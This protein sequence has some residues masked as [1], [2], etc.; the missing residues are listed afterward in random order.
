MGFEFLCFVFMAA[1]RRQGHC[2]GNGINEWGPDGSFKEA[3]TL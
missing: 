2:T 3:V 1:T